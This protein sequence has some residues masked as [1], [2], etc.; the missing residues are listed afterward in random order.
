MEGIDIQKRIL[1][2]SERM[3]L[4]H[5]LVMNYGFAYEVK[6]YGTWQ[7]LKQDLR[8]EDH[9]KTVLLI[10]EVK[11]VNQDTVEYIQKIRLTGY[12]GLF[13]IISETKIRS[14]QIEEKIKAI[15]AGA[16]EYLSYPQTRIEMLASVKALLRC[17]RYE[18]ELKFIVAGKEFIINPSSKHVLLEG[19]NIILTKTEFAIHQYLLL[20]I[21]K[22]ISYKELYEVVWGKEYL[23]D[24]MNIMA[25]I[26]RIRKKIGDDPKNPKY[27]QNVYGIGYIVQGERCYS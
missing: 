11:G 21:N 24:D 9:S 22:T 25:H 16:D 13:L 14:V 26:H 10:W 5:H 27:I 17:F 1:I 6:R 20:N 4:Y 8:T 23:S 19:E 15:D 18:G 7:D 12:M 3:G 2:L